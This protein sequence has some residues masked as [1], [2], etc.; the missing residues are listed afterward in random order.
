MKT[1]ALYIFIL[2][3]NFIL[4]INIHAENDDTGDADGAISP[5]ALEANEIIV[6]TFEEM[7]AAL[8]VNNGITKVYLGADITMKSGGITVHS[9]KTD[10][11]IS[12][13]NPLEPEKTEPYTLTQ[14]LSSAAAVITDT[15]YVNSSGVKNVTLSD[16]NIIGKNYY[17]VVAVYEASATDGLVVTYMRVNY[18]GPQIGYHRRGTYRVIDCDVTLTA[19]NGGSTNQ[20]FAEAKYLI[21]EGKNIINSLT[22]GTSVFWQPA[23]GTF[24]VSDDSSL[25]VTAVELGT[26]YGF[27]YADGYSISISVGKRSVYNIRTSEAVNFLGQTVISSFTLEEDSVFSIETSKSSSRPAMSVSG[28]LTVSENAKFSIYG[29][30]GLT[31]TQMLLAQRTGDI[32]VKKGADFHLVAKNTDSKLALLGLYG[33]SFICEDPASVLLYNPGGRTIQSVTTAGKI[34]VSAEQVNYWTTADSGG[35]DDTPENRWKKAD[36]TNFTLSGTIAIGATGNIGTIS[37]NYETGD[38]DKGKAPDSTNFSMADGRVIALGRHEIIM[39]EVN[40]SSTEIS[41][42]TSPYAPVK[43]SYENKENVTESSEVRADDS[44][45]YFTSI[46]FGSIK[47]NS[48]VISRSK[49]KYLTAIASVLVNP[50]PTLEVSI[51]NKISFKTVSISSLNQFAYRS[52]PNWMINVSDTRQEGS[53]L[54]IYAKILSPLTIPDT[55]TSLTNSIIFIDDEGGIKF[56][57]TAAPVLIYNHTTTSNHDISKITWNHDKGILVYIPAGKVIPGIYTTTIE[58]IISDVP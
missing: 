49:Y 29:N 24:T 6:S 37:S 40:E 58:W 25:D 2:L 7:K 45:F 28:N 46:P 9:S 27:Y 55:Q 20:E 44:G 16:I 54:K 34:S 35:F 48:I 57:D 39:Y 47:G 4:L 38:S 5:R 51:P 42:K 41:G 30:V 32:T 14:Y 21:F 22:T 15:I 52:D 26:T 23:G 36:G 56:L 3:L 10:V 53:A 12:G 50:Y 8:S 33:R 13:L 19:E 18:R 11:Y 1:K 31:A 43:V 17:G